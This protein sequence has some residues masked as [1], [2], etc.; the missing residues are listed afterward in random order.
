LS[1]KNSAP[2]Q[3]PKQQR[4]SGLERLPFEVR[5]RIYSYLGISSG[6][7][8]NGKSAIPREANFIWQTQTWAH[9]GS[10]FEHSL[11]GVSHTLR[12]EVLDILFF[13]VV[14]VFRYALSERKIFYNGWANVNS[15]V[16]LP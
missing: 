4:L 9:W 14:A 15:S 11:L 5:E 6:E 12:A 2:Y 1:A 7:W 10:D 16:F 3:L 8:S 13:K